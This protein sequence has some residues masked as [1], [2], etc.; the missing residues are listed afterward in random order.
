MTRVKTPKYLKIKSTELKQ[1]V[2]WA[3]VGTGYAQGGSYSQ[4]IPKIIVK[5]MK[6]LKLG[7]VNFS[8]FKSPLDKNKLSNAVLEEYLTLQEKCKG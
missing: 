7:P 4:T 6:R 1:L 8:C 5:E 2:F 3:H